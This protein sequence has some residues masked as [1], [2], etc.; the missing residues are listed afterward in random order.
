MAALD[1][2]EVESIRHL[3]DRF[4]EDEATVRDLIERDPT[5]A[6]LCQEYRQTENELQRLRRRH[7][8]VEEELLARIEGY[9]PT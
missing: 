1:V 6:A 3:L 5:F 9:R 8:Q 2:T 7:E 4:A